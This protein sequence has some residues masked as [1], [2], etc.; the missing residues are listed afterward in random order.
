MA[1]QPA[2]SARPKL[3][4]NLFKAGEVAAFIPPL[5][6][7]DFVA[8][9]PCSGQGAS[10]RS[11]FVSVSEKLQGSSGGAAAVS[12]GWEWGLGG[13][14]DTVSP[15]WLLFLSL[16]PQVI[17]EQ[18]G[19]VQFKITEVHAAAQLQ[20][21]SKASDVAVCGGLELELE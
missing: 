8:L 14:S 9:P 13:G 15:T 11:N 12:W 7:M 20:R 16:R 19:K 17:R 3:L 5:P 21:D 1:Y 18:L 4:L 10:F 6:S 2:K